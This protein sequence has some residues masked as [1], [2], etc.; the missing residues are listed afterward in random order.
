MPDP[1]PFA[2]TDTLTHAVGYLIVG[3]FMLVAAPE[4]VDNAIMLMGQDRPLALGFVLATLCAIPSLF[5]LSYQS[6]RENL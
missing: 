4:L 5:Y 3:L 6:F 2:R 1:F